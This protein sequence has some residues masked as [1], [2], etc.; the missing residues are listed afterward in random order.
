MNRLVEA[1]GCAPPILV[2]DPREERQTAAQQ[3]QARPGARSDAPEGRESEEIAAADAAAQ[4]EH[5]RTPDDLAFWRGAVTAACI[6]ACVWIVI[7]ALAWAA[8]KGL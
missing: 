5:P 1:G 8:W 3:P 4:N 7:A 6:S 2:G